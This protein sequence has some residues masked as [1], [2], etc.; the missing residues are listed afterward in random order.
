[1][2]SFEAK[3]RAKINLSLDVTGKRPD[4]YHIVKMIM[5]SIDLHDNVFIEVADGG[6]EVTSDCYWLPSGSENIAYKAA[7][8]MFDRFGINKG[9]KIRIEKRI[10]VAAGL[11]GGSTDAAA[12]L[13]GINQLFKLDIDESELMIIGKQIGA[14]VPYCIK[15]GTM[16]A[17][18]IGE[19]LTELAPLPEVYLVLVKPKIGVSTAWVYKNLN[20]NQEL[21]RPDTEVLITAIKDN[22]LDVLAKGMKNVL[23]TVTISKYKVI[24]EIKTKLLEL[25]ALGSMMSGSGPTVFGIFDSLD[26]AQY[27][28]DRIK[29]DRWECFLTKT[30]SG[31]I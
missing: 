31:G 18:G 21:D 22:R 15:G 3:A 23:E 10:P 26:S 8:I 5:Q 30:V 2:H 13:K 6:I 28:L 4:G 7:K 24:Q 16:L 20:I 27:A 17:E 25:G 11:A 14:D 1:M 19:I 29:T 12:V 9:I